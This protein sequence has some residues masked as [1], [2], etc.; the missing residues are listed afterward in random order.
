MKATNYCIRFGHS[1]WSAIAVA[2]AS[3]SNM[4]TLPTLFIFLMVVVSLL[5]FFDRRNVK[6]GK[7]GKSEINYRNA[8]ENK[9]LSTGEKNSAHSVVDEGISN[10]KCLFILSLC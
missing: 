4:Q 2:S 6:L 9:H 8:E 7:W 5:K 3:G 10:L 1:L